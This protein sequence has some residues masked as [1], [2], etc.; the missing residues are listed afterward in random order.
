MSSNKPVIKLATRSNNNLPT[1]QCY[2]LVVTPVDKMTK[3]AREMEMKSACRNWAGILRS[4]IPMIPRPRENLFP[5]LLSRRRF[6]L[7]L[8]F[9]N[10]FFQCF[11]TFFPRPGLRLLLTLLF[12]RDGR[13]P[14]ELCLIDFMNLLFLREPAGLVWFMP[15]DFF[16]RR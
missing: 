6:F 13:G 1:F 4:R 2:S 12:G 11:F 5:A 16:Q 3:L 10:S 14:P 15:A 9:N 7:L 8:N